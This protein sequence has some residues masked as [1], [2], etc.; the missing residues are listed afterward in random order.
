MIIIEKEEN[1]ENPTIEIPRTSSRTNLCS[2]T[3]SSKTL[4]QVEKVC[5]RM[6]Q[7]QYL[8]KISHHLH[9]W[10]IPYRYYQANMDPAK[11]FLQNNTIR[12]HNSRVYWNNKILFYF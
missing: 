3:R 11:A 9:S 4:R 7:Q 8:I 1:N 12:N 10:E 6:G 2:Q 5:Y